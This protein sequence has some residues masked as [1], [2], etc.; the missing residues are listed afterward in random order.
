MSWDA[1][2]DEIEKRRRMAKA[3]GGDAAI[4]KHHAKG[5][6]TIRE[7]IAGLL[8]EGSFAELGEGA[9]EAEFDDTGALTGFT[10]PN[11]VLGHGRIGGRP[12]IV[13]GEDFT[14]KGGSPN[15]AGLRKSVYSEELA[16]Q[17]QAPLV[18]LLEGGGGSVAGSGGKGPKRP[19][20]GDA[21]NAPPRF[22]SITRVLG[23]V[24]VASAALGPV[25]GF[26]AARLAAS[27]FSVMTEETAQVLVAGPQVV[28]RAL[29]RD[30]TKEEL[31]GADIHLRSGVVDNAARDEQH[32][33]EQIADFLSFLPPN[34]HELP[35]R[36]ESADSPH[37]AED[38]LQSLVPRDR[39]QPYA[40]RKLI[41]AV[42]DSGSFF[43]MTRKYGPGQI[44]GFA[45]LDGV[46][47]G[48]LANDCHFYAG[49][50]TADG[51]QKVRRF[52]DLCDT[53]HL[54]IVSFVDEP[55]F[56][57]GPDAEKA[58]TIRYGTAAIAAVMESK[59]PWAA[60]IIRKTFG[61]A[62]AAHFGPGCYTL[63]WPSAEMGA[64]PVEGGVAVAF[65]RQIAEADDPDAMRA[66]L[67]AK[68][69]A[70]QS[71]FPRAEAFGFHELIAPRETRSYLTGWA[72]R[73]WPLLKHDLGPRAYGY[74]P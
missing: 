58:G 53:F 74:R 72:N 30:L 9:G 33:F 63:A 44:T 55:G 1:E 43:E 32:A 41:K 69:A 16:L 29:G 57:I 19:S 21:V 28:A 49:A 40:M 45:R 25:A 3:Q 65:G 11:Y 50:M 61:V 34:V 8:D 38:S 62:G 71:P 2:S 42:A 37:R 20:G 13:G 23:T 70:M 15:P 17:Y 51:A 14:L 48:I 6:L 4:A 64:L 54:P 27:H 35:P 36:T 46:P 68:L 66:Q 24:P 59:V 7:R 52:V 47:V 22:M 60:V 31:G 10:P 12:V 18:R 26:P 73:V 5:R 39:R 67:E 56:M